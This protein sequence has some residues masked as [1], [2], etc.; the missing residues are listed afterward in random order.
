MKNMKIISNLRAVLLMVLLLVG[1]NAFADGESGRT[2]GLLQDVSG[3]K[4]TLKLGSGSAG[5]EYNLVGRYFITA[6]QRY[7]DVGDFAHA[8]FT[9]DYV[10]LATKMGCAESTLNTADSYWFPVPNA[11][12]KETNKDNWLNENGE[13]TGWDNGVLDRYFI[14]IDEGNGDIWFGQ[15]PGKYPSGSS[16]DG[17]IYLVST[18]QECNNVVEIKYL[19]NFV[20]SENT[21]HRFVAD[22]VD[23]GNTVSEGVHNFQNTENSRGEWSGQTYRH[24]GGGKWFSYDLSLANV[25]D[26]PK[27]KVSLVVRYW[28]SDWDNR[29]FNIMVDD[30]IIRNQMLERNTG[31]GFKEYEYPVDPALLDGKGK[32]TVKF[33]S[34][35]NKTAGG[36]YFV[37]LCTGYSVPARS[38]PAYQFKSTDFEANENITINSTKNN[39]VHFTGTAIANY[40]FNIRIS[41]SV[42]HVSYMPDQYLFVIAG[43]GFKEQSAEISWLMGNNCN[44]V[45]KKTKTVNGTTYLIFDLRRKNSDTFGLWGN[46]EVPFASTNNEP[47]ALLCFGLTPTDDNTEFKGTLS[48]AAFYSPHELYAKYPDVFTLNEIC[49]FTG[50]VAN[51]QFIHDGY[52]YQINENNTAVSRGMKLSVDAKEADPEYV[53]GYPFALSLTNT[54]ALPTYTANHHYKVSVTRN[55]QAGYNTIALPFDVANVGEAFGGGAFVA[56]L[57]GATETDGVWTLTFDKGNEIKAN[58]PYILYMPEAKETIGFGL[59]QVKAAESTSVKYN[60]W[61]MKSNYTPGFSMSGLYGV[62]PSTG[63]VMRGGSNATLNGLAAYLQYAGEGNV[64]TVS[65]FDEE[66]GIQTTID[67]NVGRDCYD[68][69]GRKVSPSAVK[70]VYIV[71]GKKYIR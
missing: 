27:D 58:A 63:K 20:L 22:Y 67:N 28:G 44:L 46:E 18:N 31:D 21:D 25:T 57:S 52:V 40:N 54:D 64:R 29:Y 70:G 35:R 14:Q 5:K 66:T 33:Q 4:V 38:L 13:K 10:T 3:E 71:N 43:T 30:V 24:V 9:P 61:S 39:V 55:L 12:Y 51:Q 15:Y 49:E 7:K 36:I 37:K 6:S 42:E 34:A 45:P 60:K 65:V 16:V 48:D 59:Q 50:Y 26:V 19:L 1:S 17:T 53:N 2:T 68:L 23:V 11:D 8:I 56:Q 41:R 69:S 47:K 62:V 32:I